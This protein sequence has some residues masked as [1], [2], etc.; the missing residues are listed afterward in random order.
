MEIARHLGDL[1]AVAHP[2]VQAQY[3]VSV[4]VIFDAVE[5]AALADHVHAGITE[6]TQVGTFDL[7]A[8]LFGHG[9]HAVA[10]A[11]HRHVQVEH[12]LRR[13]RAVGFVDR[14]GAAGEDDAARVEFADRFIVHVERVQLAVHADLAHAA[15]NQLGVLGTEIEDQDAVSVNVEGHDSISDAVASVKPQ[16]A[17]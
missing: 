14:L 9:L 10:D 3:A 8:H 5:Q 1:V 17:S 7:A 15:G 2:H 11:Q 13:A 16:A 6:L 4:D 12:C